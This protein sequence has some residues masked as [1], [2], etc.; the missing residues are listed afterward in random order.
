[1]AQYKVL[2]DEDVDF[3]N[4]I[5]PKLG[6]S[7]MSGGPSKI[8]DEEVEVDSPE[9]EPSIGTSEATKSVVETYE[10]DY[11][12]QIHDL[13]C[14]KCINYILKQLNIPQVEIPQVSIPE[15]PDISSFNINGVDINHDPAKAE[16]ADAEQMKNKINDVKE[17]VSK[18]TGNINKKILEPI[19]ACGGEW[20]APATGALVHNRLIDICN[21]AYE[22]GDQ[23]AAQ[24]DKVA[25]EVLNMAN[26]SLGNLS[27]F[28]ED[29]KNQVVES[30]KKNIIEKNEKKVKD[31]VEKEAKDAYNKLEEQKTK[32]KM[33]AD[34][35]KQQLIMQLAALLGF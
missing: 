11:Q 2:T 24:V 17:K 22:G 31:K 35:I 4:R 26:I 6:A 1:M 25:Q 33:K 5:I 34:F 9:L 19:S 21:K 16:K 12:Q 27:K 18:L 7:F 23:V 13:I 8:H 14:P 20:N 3:I 28:V 32:A 29:A 30:V 15:P 10:E